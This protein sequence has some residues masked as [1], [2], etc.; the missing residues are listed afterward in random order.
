MT[1]V[2]A[3]DLRFAP[4]DRVLI[5]G[6]TGFIGAHLARRC[7][8]D[9]AEVTIAG[10][11]PRAAAAGPLTAV[12]CDVKDRDAVKALFTGRAY[13]YVFNLAGYIDHR[14]YAQG[15]R[16]VIDQHLGGL[17]N[18]LDAIDRR[19]LKRFVQAGSS[20]EYGDAA[21]PQREDARGRV[22]APYAWAKRACSD[23]LVTLARTEA[24]PASVARLFLVYGPGQ[25]QNRLVPQTIRACLDGEPFAVTEGRQLRDFCFVAD[26][27]DGLA[28]LAL[29]DAARGEIVNVASGRAV[30]VRE[31]VEAVVRVIGRGEPQFGAR[32]YRAGESMLLVAD[33]TKAAD[34]LEWSPATD[35]DSGLRQ[36]VTFYK[37]RT[38]TCRQ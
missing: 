18:V 12:A 13:E 38:A 28:R 20:D 21:G 10:R 22:A 5:L 4:A 24:F 27:A 16:D 2:R 6:G 1:H 36:T 34:L 17:L 32:P 31:M 15:G 30:S 37:E 26:A 33:V 3:T 7:A 29:S 8:A 9:G 14:P 11:A 25:D 19:A 35:L 23:L